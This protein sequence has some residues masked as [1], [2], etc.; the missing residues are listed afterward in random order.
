[1][2]EAGGRT[3]RSEAWPPLPFPAW[4]ET[5]ATLHMWTQIVGKVMLELTPFLNEWWNVALHLTPRGLTSGPIAD[6]ERTFAIDFDF[7]GHTLV[8]RTGEGVVWTMPL[9]PRSVAD[10][11]AEFMAGMKML[12]LNVAINPLP[13][14]VPDPIP[15]HQDHEHASYDAD[16]VERWWRVLAQTDALLRRFRTPFVGKSSPVQFFW[17]SFDLNHTRFS[18]LPALPPA[19][20]PRF[21]QLAEDQENFACGF[22]PGN[23]GP[24]GLTLGEPAFYAYIY[25]EPAEFRAAAI[26]P[27]TALFHPDFG[28]FILPYE[29]AR[30]TASPEET[31]LAFFD[32]AYESAATYAG[33]NRDRLERPHR[34]SVSL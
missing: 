32:S 3:E 23:A 33:W 20:W 8:V 16:A 21:M 9:I 13:V 15:F 25:P 11:Y 17:G 24:A 1:M 19:N 10:F 27:E 7:I 29:A 6:G 34:A 18:G 4:Q 26:L 2:V 30:Q 22:W 14:E 5:Q 28:E 12:E 31:V